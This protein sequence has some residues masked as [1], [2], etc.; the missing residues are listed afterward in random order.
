MKV[1][2]CLLLRREDGLL[3]IYDPKKQQKIQ[4]T[5][6]KPWVHFPF[7]KVSYLTPIRVINPFI[8]TENEFET[9]PDTLILLNPNILVNARRI[10]TASACP[11]RAFIEF[12][13]GETKTSLPMVRGS[14]IHDAFSTIVIKNISVQ[15]ALD[16][17]LEKFAFQL[18]YL[19]ADLKELRTD[20]MP[21]LRGLARSAPTL[22]KN[23]V[24]P[25]V[26][27][28]CPLYGLMGRLDYW[29]PIELYELK[30][31]R[32]IPPREKNTWF[33]DLM[34]TVIYMHGLSPFPEKAVSKSAVIYSGEGTPNFRQTTLNLDLFQK[35]HMGRNY[36]YLIQFEDW[37]PPVLESTTCSYCFTKEAC[38]S[39]SQW[40]NEQKTSPSISFQYLTHFLSLIRFEHLKNRQDFAL[41][42]KL[43]PKG[44]VKI[45][46]AIENIQLSTTKN[47]PGLYDYNCTNL[48]ELRPGEPVVV[49]QGDP[50]FDNTNLAIITTIDRNK[51]I[52]KSENTLPKQAY[53][54]AYSSD[55]MF[56]RLNKNLYDITVG[57]KSHHK[58]NELV[59]RGKKPSFSS[60]KAII[61]ERLDPSQKKAVQLALC[62]NDY[63]LIQG[64]AGTGKTYTIAHL[65]TLLRKKGERILLSAYTNTAVDNIIRQY[66][67]FAQ[68]KEAEN[69]IVRLGIE[70]AIDPDVVQ[71]SLQYKKLNYQDL[72]KTPIVAA[73]T[74]TISSTIYDDLTFDTVI[75]DEA[76]QMAEPYVLSAIQKGKFILVG[77]HQQLPPL[78]QSYRAEKLGLG[79]SL[80]ER[81]R[82]LHP[83]A[84]TLLQYQYRMHNDLMA[85]SNQKFYANRVRAGSESV[86]NQLLWELIPEDAE[87]PVSDTLFQV[88]LDPN[89]PL[90][91]VEVSGKFERKR[92]I[93]RRE[94]DVINA[95]VEYYLQMGIRED[96]IG[97][98]APFRGQVAEI[99][100][101]VGIETGITVDTI[102]RFQGS[103]RELIFLS[104]CTLSPPHILE[105]KR[106]LNVA[107]TRAKKKLIIV[108]NCPTK[109]SIP[110]FQDL[111]NFIK[112][113]HTLVR[114]DP[115]NL[116]PEEMMDSDREPR[117]D[118]DMSHLSIAQEDI[119]KQ[120]S[121]IVEHHI[122][123]LCQEPVEDEVVLR[124]PICNQAYH[125]NHLQDWLAA[126]DVCVTCQSRIQI[127]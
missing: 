28:L 42:W 127:T 13:T 44:R 119:N 8:I 16:E 60:E 20:V 47:F 48:S 65:I 116:E 123:I 39:L 18:S 106:R 73:T 19:S 85:F 84:C 51:V 76:S 30:T 55:F 64:P 77:D 41:L 59:I 52:L 90:I 118:S 22:R 68:A 126:N 57:Q 96:H 120:S 117:I 1:T 49:S 122:C 89:Q 54:D 100:R 94:G 75:V 35:I 71:L 50:V 82:K 78:V 72:E 74:S 110:L 32:K 7:S 109:E 36:C 53:L 43:S 83:E 38:L 23:R 46:K 69:E 12:I 95:L 105:D 97:V 61:E 103:D 63:C 17:G 3:I 108:G 56:R 15:E 121:I 101:L 26:T 98:I 113:N 37:V 99:L 70:E 31:S 79:M 81:L 86:A 115:I 124:C 107:L 34:Q 10:A 14:L 93:N 29:S 6:H 2:N 67:K 88:I 87:L 92:R 58:T 21:V 91:Y 40:F 5:L 33:S 104:L 27:F 24:L 9:T 66:L 114:L 11:R 25:E 112:Q 4:L 62:A 102:D 45:G 111:Y 125:T 80:F